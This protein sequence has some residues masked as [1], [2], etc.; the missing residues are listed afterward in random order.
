M[1]PINFEQIRN[2][3]I[4]LKLPGIILELYDGNCNIELLQSSFQDPYVI[5]TLNKNQQDKYLIDRYKPLLAYYTE[6]IFAYDIISKKYVKYS[7]ELFDE[8]VLEPMSWDS[9][10]INFIIG[11]WEDGDYAEDEIVNYGKYL[12]VKNTGKILEERIEIED[13]KLNYLEYMKWEKSLIK[14]IDN[15][16]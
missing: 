8:K 2:L 14:L 11:L 5:F 10:F 6:T 12:G 7:I 13:K 1:E 15:K 16:N 4:E 3:I 9:L